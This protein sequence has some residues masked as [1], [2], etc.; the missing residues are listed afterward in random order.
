MFGEEAGKH[1]S[2]CGV[3]L[4]RRGSI[5]VACDAFDTSGADADVPTTLA[6]K[7]TTLANYQIHLTTGRRSATPFALVSVI[8]ARRRHA[9]RLHPATRAQLKPASR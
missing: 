6:V 1:D 8:N 3:E 9:Y 5:D 7:Q 2:P 4:F